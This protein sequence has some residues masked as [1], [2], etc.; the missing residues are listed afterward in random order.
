MA[1]KI[2]NYENLISNAKII[3]STLSNKAKFCAVIK[4]NAYGHG[5]K[6]I[7]NKI[8]N[9]VDYFAVIDNSEA[10]E[11]RKFTQNPILVLGKLSQEKLEECIQNN[12]EFCVCKSH[13]I[14]LLNSLNG[15]K[16][17]HIAINTGMNRLGIN[18][19]EE[20]DLLV[21]KIGKIQNIEIVGIFSHISD[22]KNKKRTYNQYNKL[23]EITQNYKSNCIYHLLSS[24]CTYLYPKIKLD[25][26]R[27][28]IGLYGYGKFPTQPVMEVYSKVIEIKDLKKGEFVGYTSKHRVKK[29]CKIAILDIGYADGLNRLWAKKGFVILNDSYCK[30]VGEICM[31]MTMVEV[32]NNCKINDTAIILGSKNNKSITANDMAKKIKTIPYEIL[33][34]FNKLSI[35]N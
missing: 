9:I 8:E 7:A 18:S 13:D 28:G 30:I 21:E 31:N 32:D 25:M 16:K 5:L 26:A 4:S 33:T 15:N 27:I 24:N 1:Y 34:N 2:I 12:I 11:L 14:D 19:Q 17:I 6:E 23:K 29:D 20:F 35:K 22:S 10:L 3:K